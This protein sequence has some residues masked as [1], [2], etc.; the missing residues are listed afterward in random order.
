MGTADEAATI[1]QSPDFE[2]TLQLLR[3][4]D[5]PIS[6]LTETHMRHFFYLG[7]PKVPVGLV[8][9]EFHDSDAL[10]RS[11]VVA[12]ESR[13]RGAG[14][15]LVEHAETYARDHGA[16][17][18]YILTT[19]AERFFRARGYVTAS[20][21]HAP[22]AIKGTAEFSSLCPASSVFLSKRL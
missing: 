17:A 20:R 8:G 22:V 14:T 5:L 13:S 15:Q 1:H 2:A 19:T 18:I 4:A 11:L 7:P 12:P 6:D 16:V 9:V 3:S 21:E 10:L